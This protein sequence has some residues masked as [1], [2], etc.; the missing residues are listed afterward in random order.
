MLFFGLVIV[1]LAALYFVSRGAKM[2]GSEVQ[3]EKMWDEQEAAA[4]SA[5][6]F[7][8]APP[9]MAPPAEENE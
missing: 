7:V 5:E 6:T 3:I 1:L 2:P 9:P 8:P 4:K